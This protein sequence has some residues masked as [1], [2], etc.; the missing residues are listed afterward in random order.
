M[1]TWK[2]RWL[3]NP[4]GCSIFHVPT[5]NQHLIRTTIP[6]SHCFIPKGHSAAAAS[7]TEKHAPNKSPFELLF[8]N[9]ATTD[10]TPYLTA[11]AAL[12]FRAQIPGGEEAI[13]TY[14]REI[15]FEGG[16][17]VAQ[18]LGTEVLGEGLADGR[19]CRVRE[20]GFA[21][22]RL[23]FLVLDSGKVAGDGLKGESQ[24]P[25]L[26]PSQ[27][28]AVARWMQERLVA[29]YSTSVTALVHN[30]ALWA[31]ISGQIYLEMGD[32]QWLGQALKELCDRVGSDL[33]GVVG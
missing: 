11:P 19:L 3:Y 29:E 20:C 30:S 18:I 1:L 23:P 6:T 13:F 33:D 9:V 21:N 15:A 2:E 28:V 24:W 16:N 5:R 26:S 14:I 7:A 27:A 4:R 12:K 17:L 32:F 31:R 8:Q 22:V 10:D 25:V